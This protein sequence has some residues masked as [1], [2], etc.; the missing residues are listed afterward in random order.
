MNKDRLSEEELRG[1]ME[2][3]AESIDLDS[4]NFEGSATIMEESIIT[5][6]KKASKRLSKKLD[7]LNENLSKEAPGTLTELSNYEKFLDEA[8]KILNGAYRQIFLGPG[9]MRSRKCSRCVYGNLHLP[10][11]F[12]LIGGK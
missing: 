2:K 10:E 3:V 1:L 8:D 12:E 9:R 7:F 5:R 11:D 4:E 6:L